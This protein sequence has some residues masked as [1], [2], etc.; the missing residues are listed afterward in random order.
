[1]K[2]VLLVLSVIGVIMSMRMLDYVSGSRTVPAVD[3]L[4][5]GIFFLAFS[6][7]AWAYSLRRTWEEYF[8]KEKEII[9]QSEDDE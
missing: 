1:M 4:I 6:A 2:E 7:A 5:W 8:A 3:M 9:N